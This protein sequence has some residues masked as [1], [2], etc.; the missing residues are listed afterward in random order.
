MGFADFLKRLTP[1]NVVEDS[2]EFPEEEKLE[3]KMN[4]RIE[5][6]TGLGDLDRIANYLKQGHVVLVKMK[7]VQKNDIGL[8]Q[9]IMQKMK[10]LSMQ[11]NWD[12]VALQ[13]GYLIVTPNFAR[14]ERPEQF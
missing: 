8:F 6:V 11:F 2:V 13:E 12:L 9:T 1:K 3:E 14:I 4:V 5:N 10:R 7:D